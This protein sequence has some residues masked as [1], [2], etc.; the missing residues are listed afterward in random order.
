VETNGD[1][2][3]LMKLS[4]ACDLAVQAA[5]DLGKPLPPPL[6]GAISDLCVAIQEELERR[7]ERFVQP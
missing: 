2:D 5:R 7:D 4:V 3:A 6:E 1:L